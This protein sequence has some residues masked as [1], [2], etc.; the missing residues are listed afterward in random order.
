MTKL[1]KAINCA[2]ILI[3]FFW[4]KHIIYM[5]SIHLGVELLSQKVCT[6]SL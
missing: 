5:L 3:S 2:P 1:K 4:W 6:F